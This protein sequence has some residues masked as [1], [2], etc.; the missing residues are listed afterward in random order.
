M[1]Y[2]LTI[3]QKPTYLHAI[4][5]GWNSKENVIRYMNDV[6]RERIARSDYKVLIEQRLEGPRLSVHAFRTA[7]M[8]EA[9]RPAIC[10]GRWPTST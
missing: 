7:S 9:A 10:Y 3:D 6:L 4:I 1:T 2:E 5:T 8:G